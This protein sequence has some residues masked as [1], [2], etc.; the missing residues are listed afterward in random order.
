MLFRADI[1]FLRAYAI[2][3]VVGYHFFPAIFASG[4]IGVDIFFVI[5]GYLMSCLLFA[6][7]DRFRVLYVDFLLKRIQR[8]FP[9]LLLLVLSLLVVFIIFAPYFEVIAFA[10]EALFS[11]SFVSNLRY[12]SILDYFDAVSHNKWL[13]HTWSLSVEMQVYLMLPVF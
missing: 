12:L 7:S 3:S 9:E 2:A 10:K 6:K 4:Y 8:I 13:L 5:S 1:N 11:L